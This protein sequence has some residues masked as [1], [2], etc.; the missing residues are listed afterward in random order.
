MGGLPMVVFF[1][2]IATYR[3]NDSPAPISPFRLLVGYGSAFVVCVVLSAFSAYV[4]PEDASSIW[5]VSPEHYREAIVREFLSNLILST[6]LAGLGIAA[7]GVPVIFRL[8]RPGRAQVGWVLLA[9]LLISVAFSVLLGVTVL[10]I[11]VNW[12]SDFLTLLGYSLFMHLLLS[13]GFSMGAGLPW[14]MHRQV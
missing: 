8:A 6:S 4:S 3:A 12:L 14:R 7:I 13:L 9:S 1:L 5:H 2:S 11:S 10:Q